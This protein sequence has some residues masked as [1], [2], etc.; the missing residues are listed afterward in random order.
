MRG[1]EVH[2]P[3]SQLWSCCRLAGRPWENS[4]VFCAFKLSSENWG[5]DSD[6]FYIKA[7]MKT[8]LSNVY[9]VMYIKLFGLSLA[10]GKGLITIS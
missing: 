9:G 7:I 4:L 10:T 5:E 6:N 2:R 8:K 1:C 3:E